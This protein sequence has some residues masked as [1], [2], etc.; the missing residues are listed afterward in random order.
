MDSDTTHSLSAQYQILYNPR[1]DLN[2]LMPQFHNG[3]TRPAYGATRPALGVDGG[4]GGQMYCG[5]VWEFEQ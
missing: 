4:G 2:F 1:E 3:A 5:I